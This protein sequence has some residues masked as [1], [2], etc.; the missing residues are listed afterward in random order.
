SD[1]HYH[2]SRRYQSLRHFDDAPQLPSGYFGMFLLAYVP[3]LWRR[4][5]DPRTLALVDGD[6]GKLNVDPA[7]CRKG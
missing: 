5:I 2:A 3:F 7:V 4:V 1:H 6:L